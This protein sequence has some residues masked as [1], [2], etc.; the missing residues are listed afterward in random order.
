MT[1]LL[2]VL[3]RSL[4][5]GFNVFDV[6][7][8]GV[9]EKQISNVFRWL[10]EADGT[11]GFGD[12]FVRIFIEQINASLPAEEQLPYETYWVRQEVNT[13][14]SGVGP[15]IAD[16]VLESK[17]TC[18]VVENYFTS[19]GHGHSFDGYLGYAL[20][21]RARGIVVLLCRDH[22]VSLQTQGWQR[23]PVATYSGLVGRLHADL[24]QDPA[25]Q[26]N[27]A[28]AYSFIEQMHRKF[29]TGR[30]RMNDDDVLGFVVAMCDTGEARRYQE[31][32]Q[33]AAAERF[34]SDLAEQARERFGEGRELL[35]QV[36]R[37]VKEFGSGVLAAQL[38]QTLGDGFV[39]NVSATFSGIY[40][41]TVNFDIDDRGP[42]FGEARLQ[43]KFGPSAWFA[44]E[45]DPNWNFI[46]DSLGADYSRLFITRA[47]TKE[48][49]QSAVTL[50]EVL[51]GL[52]PTDRRL[53]DE[54]VAILQPGR[55]S[56]GHPVS[57]NQ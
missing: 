31:Q 13:S 32:K 54:V 25:Y 2:P 24:E 9:H 50:Q 42:E 49:R 14:V 30:G 5:P 11:H 19:D 1:G 23:A 17:T 35:H 34:A 12:R 43:L 53:H 15:D 37:L 47:A 52:E 48:I 33:H 20:G 38:E 27:H 7:H 18:I 28:E 10:L 51:D 44:I 40:Q 55:G 8:H 3:G 57:A 39:R 46:G 21:R 4:E 29:V 6:M 45:N 56:S 22:H 26:R 41:W 16:L 36:K